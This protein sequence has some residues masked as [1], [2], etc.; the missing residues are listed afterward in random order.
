VRKLLRGVLARLG[1]AV[2]VLILADAL[3]C[4]NTL[5]VPHVS[6]G[7]IGG[8]REV[9]IVARDRVTL[10]ASY[11]VPPVSTGRCVLALHGIGDTRE[12]MTYFSDM[13]LAQGYGI[14]LPDSRAH[15]ESGGMMITYGLLEKLDALD[16]AYWLRQQG[17]AQVYGFGE[18]LGGAVLIQAAAVEPAFR[19]IVAECPYSSLESVAEYRIAGMTHLPAWAGYAFAWPI[20]KS[21]E[22]YARATYGVALGSVSPVTDIARTQT[23]VLLIHGLS[24]KETPPSQSEA[25]ARANSHASLWLVPNAGHVEASFVEP[26]EFRRRVLA[27]FSKN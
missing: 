18:S 13:F 23:P 26:Q 25:L 17:C 24:D 5:H 10:A 16:W 15:G 3:L 12:G 8:A 11:L 6:P 4:H 22:I 19:A 1:L 21:T 7:P 27:W 20:V 9:T 14:L 2:A